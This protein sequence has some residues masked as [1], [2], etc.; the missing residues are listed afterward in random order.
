MIYSVQ[1]TEYDTCAFNPELPSTEPR[2]GKTPTY[3]FIHRP[4]TPVSNK[5]SIL[6]THCP[7][8]CS[9]TGQLAYRQIV[10]GT[11]FTSLSPCVCCHD[12]HRVRWAGFPSM[13]LYLETLEISTHRAFGILM[14]LRMPKRRDH[15]STFSMIRCNAY[16][17]M[18]IP[19]VRSL[20]LIFCSFCPEESQWFIC[21]LTCLLLVMGVGCFTWQMTVVL[22]FWVMVR[23]DRMILFVQST[24]SIHLVFLFY[25]QS[26]V[27][28]VL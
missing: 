9:L 8:I 26:T 23:V 17:H 16:W 19:P 13:V 7:P 18:I 1:S 3:E 5:L 27:C 2:K 6:I 21:R 25:I 20:L 22:V 11:L 15:A 24:V 12:R 4:V 28:A 10:H 14:M